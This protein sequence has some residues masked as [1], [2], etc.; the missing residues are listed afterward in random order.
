M[1]NRVDEVKPD[2]YHATTTMW[3]LKQQAIVAESHGWVVFFDYS[4]GRPANLLEAGGVHADLYRALSAKSKVL[5]ERRAAWDLAHP[6]K[7]RAAKL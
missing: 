4:T 2:R 1:A 3:S 6:K 5:N 7:P